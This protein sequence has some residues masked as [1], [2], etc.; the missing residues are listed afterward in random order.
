MRWLAGITDLMDMILSKLQELAMDREPWSAAVHGVKKHQTQL[1]GPLLLLLPPGAICGTC[2][3]WHTV[4][5]NVI[6]ML[7]FI[8]IPENKAQS[9]AGG[10]RLKGKKAPGVY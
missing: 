7:L 9:P 8:M 1:A 6:S 5:F 2:F 10:E 3:L 4:T